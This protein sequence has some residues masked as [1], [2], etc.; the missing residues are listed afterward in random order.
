[1][2][3]SVLATVTAFLVL[4]AGLGCRPAAKPPPGEKPATPHAQGPGARQDSPGP[5][6]H[7]AGPDGGQ[8]APAA[9]AAAWQDVAIVGLQDSPSRDRTPYASCLA[10]EGDAMWVGTNVGLL[11]IDLKTGQQR[12]YR[13]ADSGVATLYA[14][15]DSACPAMC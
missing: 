4:S 15:L 2:R 11:W 8:A 7:P 13:E 12:R 3:T 5:A 6:A 1:M 10:P 14:N 9:G